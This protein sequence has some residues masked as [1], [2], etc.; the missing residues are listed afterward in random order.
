[1]Y[2][3]VLTNLHLANYGGIHVDVRG[4]I[5]NF[6]PHNIAVLIEYL[7]LCKMDT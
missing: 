5:S 7:L 6:C 3:C 4:E 2:T 1:M